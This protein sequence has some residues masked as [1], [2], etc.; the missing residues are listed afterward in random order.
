MFEFSFAGVLCAILLG[1]V[2]RHFFPKQF[3]GLVTTGEAAIHARL[4]LL[5]HKV[6]ITE[7]ALNPPTAAPVVPVALAPAPPAA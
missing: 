1:A 7:Q 2:T 6:G 4:V 5:E 3:L